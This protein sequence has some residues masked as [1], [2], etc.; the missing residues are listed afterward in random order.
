[1]DGRKVFT[2]GDLSIHKS[3]RK[4]HENAPE[5][6]ELLMD[7]IKSLATQMWSKMP[8]SLQVVYWT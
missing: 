2:N 7:N 6:D 5:H 3:R 4:P 8:K 1:M